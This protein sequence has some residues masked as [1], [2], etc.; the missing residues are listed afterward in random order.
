[1][2]GYQT[3]N[4]CKCIF[5]HHSI[6]TNKAFTE[7][8]IHIINRFHSLGF[9]DLY[10]ISNNKSHVLENFVNEV[11]EEDYE[12]ESED[13]QTEGNQSDEIVY[14]GPII[15][16]YVS[17]PDDIN[18]LYNKTPV[19]LNIKAEEAMVCWV[20]HYKQNFSHEEDDEMKGNFF[21]SWKKV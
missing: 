17:L 11:F 12:S 2:Y 4:N 18:L 10:K 16:E 8:K 21:I 14:N 1:M 9:F 3:C 5:Y 19:K 6:I 7:N 20:N 15:K 13:F